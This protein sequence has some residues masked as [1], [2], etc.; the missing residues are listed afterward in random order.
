M[1][2]T[3]HLF[4]GVTVALA[5][6]LAAG[7]AYA[8]NDHSWVSSTGSG[9]NCTRAVPCSGFNQA[10]A[11]TNAGGVISIIDPGDYYGL[12]ITKSLTIR[13]EGVDGGST[14]NPVFLNRFFVL[15]GASDVVTLEVVSEQF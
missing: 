8:Q 6:W 2:K 3:R 14:I 10:Q 5:S 13:A 9:P 4:V 12:F 7:S 1:T 11:I 15:A